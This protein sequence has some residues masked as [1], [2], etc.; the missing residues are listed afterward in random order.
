MLINTSNP[1]LLKD[2][3]GKPKPC[4]RK[5]MPEDFAYGYKPTVTSEGTKE[6]EIITC[7]IKSKS[8]D[9]LSI[10]LKPCGASQTGRT[11]VAKGKDLG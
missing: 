6:C 7:Q 5:L 4:T 2:D 1:L 9:F 3:V 11:N 10:S 8:L